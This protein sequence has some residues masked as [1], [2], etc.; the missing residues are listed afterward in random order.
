[1]SVTTAMAESL[2]EAW[3]VEHASGPRDCT[4]PD[5]WQ[6]EANLVIESLEARGWVLAP[7]QNGS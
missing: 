6:A 1:M 7:S 2:A 3:N 4:T 5:D